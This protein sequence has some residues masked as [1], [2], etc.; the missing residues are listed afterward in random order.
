VAGTSRHGRPRRPVPARSRGMSWRA[1]ARERRSA[2]Q[3]YLMSELLELLPGM[4]HN[5]ID[6]FLAGTEDIFVL[7]AAAIGGFA[8]N[9]ITAASV[10][11]MLKLHHV[12]KPSE[13]PTMPTHLASAIDRLARGTHFYTPLFRW[14]GDQACRYSNNGLWNYD[15]HNCLGMGGCRRFL[16]VFQR[17]W[18]ANWPIPFLREDRE[19]WSELYGR[20]GLESSASEPRFRE[21]E[22]PNQLR[23]ALKAASHLQTP[24]VFRYLTT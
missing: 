17:A 14:Q 13:W 8:R 15:V 19:G 12:E 9:E 23:K 24:N 7:I 18:E 1:V 6:V 22:L 5:S 16:A 11:A 20:R 3:F 10:R 2:S 21:F 4:P